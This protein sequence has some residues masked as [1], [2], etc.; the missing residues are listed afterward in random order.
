GELEYWGEGAA[1][2][3]EPPDT[4]PFGVGPCLSGGSI[5]PPSAPKISG[6]KVLPGV[7]RPAARGTA[8]VAAHAGARLTYNDNEEATITLKLARVATGHRAGRGCAAGK[9]RKHQRPCRRTVRLA[10]FTHAD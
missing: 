3:L 6:A 4:S 5:P 1:G 7:F 8:F 10:S 9:P 2:G